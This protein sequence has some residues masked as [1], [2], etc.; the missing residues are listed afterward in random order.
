MK[1]ENLPFC[2]TSAV[3][4]SF[5]EHGEESI[6]SVPEIE[7]LLKE[8][9]VVDLGGQGKRCVIATSVDLNNV[10][11]L[12]EAGFKVVDHYPGIQGEVYILTYHQ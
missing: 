10:E 12:M 11:I 3:L 1:I 8:L 4:G 7:R 2:C 6:V 5:G 9:R